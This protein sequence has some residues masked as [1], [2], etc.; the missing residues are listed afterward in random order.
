MNNVTIG[1]KIIG[2]NN[3]TYIIA[4]LSGNHGGNLAKAIEMLKAAHK[5]G[6]DAVKLQVYRPDT[7]TLN[8]DKDDFLIA[9]DN[10]WGKY[11]NLYNLYKYAHTPWEWLP[12]LFKV[13]RKMNIELFGSVF[14]ESA[15]DELE[16]YSVKA[17]KIAAPEIV[18]I[19]LLEKVAQTGKPVI[20]STGLGDLNDISAAVNCLRNNGCSQI[21]LLKCTTAYPAPVDEVN[22]K[23]IANLQDSFHC[24]A[25]L[26][27]HTLGIGVPIAAVALGANVIEK[28]IKL[29]D[30]DTSVDSFFSLTIKEFKQM[31]A[32]I[33]RAELAVGHVNYSIT[34]SA[35]LNK[36]GCRS[37]YVSKAIKKGETLTEQNIKSVRPGFGLEPK[38]KPLVLGKTVNCDLE[39]GDRLSWKV[40]G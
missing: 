34:P 11:H 5:A 17:Y 10:P 23:T 26:S 18:D 25:G 1:D 33:R 29:V 37:L 9:K 20:V 27:D 16:R 4:E 19:G 30:D 7:I 22:L 32:E 39:V 13:A 24:P 6:A 2:G 12:E 40:I 21:I 14:D 31:I 38:Y 8:T 15:V 36:S 28:H 3:P 35:Q